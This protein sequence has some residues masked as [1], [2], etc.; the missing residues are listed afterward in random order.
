VAEKNALYKPAGNRY[1]LCRVLAEK[2]LQT[3]RYKLVRI[4]L[5][6]I[7]REARRKLLDKILDEKGTIAVIEWWGEGSIIHKP[8]ERFYLII[9]S[10][11]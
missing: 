2:S 4:S 9:V 1:A 11:A 6:K 10:E 5:S 7:N 8:K 3:R